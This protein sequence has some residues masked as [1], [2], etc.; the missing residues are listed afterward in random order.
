M[1]EN[2]AM[3]KQSMVW[4]VRGFHHLTLY[5]AGHTGQL[6]QEQE[7]ALAVERSNIAP[8]YIIMFICVKKNLFAALVCRG[9]R[10]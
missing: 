9:S 3:S 10:L 1:T 5:S 8:P 2:F 6:M 7:H 4:G